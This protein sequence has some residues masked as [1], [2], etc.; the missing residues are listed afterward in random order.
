[1]KSH[2]SIF[3]MT[4]EEL[5]AT[6]RPT[7][8]AKSRKRNR[9]A[10]AFAKKQRTANQKAPLK[11]KVT[12][13]RDRIKEGKDLDQLWE[14]LVYGEARLLFLHDDLEQWAADYKSF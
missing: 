9:Y 12:Y 11:D 5:S 4:P 8:N 6:T 7:G 13:Y 1:M 14:R 10:R 2:K 3:E